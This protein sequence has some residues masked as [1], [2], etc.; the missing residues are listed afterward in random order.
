[1]RFFTLFLFAL[2]TIF[3]FSY[4]QTVSSDSSLF[5]AF[6]YRNVGPTRG[7]RVTTVAG[8][9][10]QAG[11]FYMGAT[12]G[13]VWKT[14]D[15]GITWKNI[16]DG[17][18]NTP[19]IGAIRVAPTNPD[20][21]YVGTGSD[22]IR[23]NVIIGKGVYKSINAGK[24]WKH[25]GLEKVGQIGAVE[26]HPTNPEIIFVAAQG[27]PFQ[28]NPERGVYQSKDG[29]ASWKQVLFVADSVGAVDVEFA[30]ANPN[31]VYATM[32]RNE[33][34]PWT[35][36]SGANKVGGVYKSTDGG[37]TWKK[38]TEGLPQGLI[39]KI[40]LAVSAADPNRLY[41]LVEAPKGEA[42]LYRSEDQ[43]NSFKLMSTKKEL[44]ARPFYYLNV[45]ANPLNADVV[46]VNEED[47]LKSTDG[48]KTWKEIRTP[49]GDNHDMWMNPRD[50]S[51]FI[52]SN[53]GGA[54]ITTNGGKT[55][56]PQD[57]QPTA[58]LYQVAVDDQYPYWLYAGQQ[59]NST[60]S[61]PSLPPYDPTRGSTSYWLAVGG[62]ETG[63]AV[64][65]PGNHN[66]V[67]S[68]CKGRFGVFDKRTG[69]ERQYYVGATNMYGHNPKD[70]VY[71]FQRV[72]PIHV[73]PH[74]PDVVYHTSQFVHMT[75]NDGISWETISPDLTANE[76]SKQVIS[77]SPI[78]RDITG[79]EYYS[80]I[81][82]I[83]ESTVKA[84]I[85]WTG[86]NDGPIYV[87][88]DAGKSW[89][90][91]TPKNV[92]SGGRVDCVEPSPH[93][94]GKAYAAILRYQLGDWK[95][96][97]VKTNDYG[98]TWTLITD[99]KNGIPE[100]Y[101]VRTIR[102]DPEKEGLLFAGTEFGLFVS[103]DDGA[104]WK[105]FQQNLPVTPVTDI[106]IF[107]NDLI[108]STMGRSFW[109]MDNISPLR[110]WNA[111][112]APN[113]FAVNDT[114]RYRYRGTGINDVPGYPAPGV[115][116]DYF[117][118]GQATNLKME[119]LNSNG[120]IIRTY[121]GKSSAKDSVK[122]TQP[123]MATGFTSS[124]SRTGLNT[125][126]GLHRFRWDMRHEGAWDANASRSLQGG[127]LIVPGK[128]TIQLMV[129]EKKFSQSFE[130][131]VDPRIKESG[132]GL[133]DLKAQEKLS[134]EIRN[135]QNSS[136]KTAE[137]IKTRRKELDKKIKEGKNVKNAKIENQELGIVLDKLVTADVIY[138]TP[139]L[140]DQLNYLSS[141]LNQ[142][143]QRPGKDAYDRLNE[144]TKKYSV[145]LEEYNKLKKRG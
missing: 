6:Q 21:V 76:P 128:Y 78:T 74:N 48:G 12:G 97:I 105:S 56:S 51:V 82:D 94:E 75:T 57:N 9:G 81:Y 77:G 38:M 29:G 15:Y 99:G 62:C 4:S 130:I 72:S 121:S 110:K 136:K 52:Q 118:S 83:N 134:L 58:E 122:A 141:M 96:Y 3:S 144:L 92:P 145:I 50:T 37:A 49:H 14:E 87:T 28:K 113:L 27:Q 55:W 109:I 89:S 66:I 127:A 41:A 111:G 8:V 119:I 70:L 108:L 7:G 17:F 24:T 79:E 53:D 138:P 35:I 60:I 64:P 16:S 22:G 112:S 90:N 93:K 84:G 125:E 95:P 116:V 129:D 36:I 86:A 140:I 33:R 69:Q 133:D 71:R 142:A 59:D 131:L 135:L 115:I 13:G 32:W 114:H 107:R 137:E 101:P 26:I 46:F 68:D 18:F 44:Y 85:I 1:M 65:K 43:G 39:G 98:S 91:V 20:I 80:T 61:V 139:M 19:S 40:D 120:N 25:I 100:D 124:T 5:K 143:D 42:G 106:K 104:T 132:V 11:T 30:P 63:P 117:L 88:K 123:D 45:D 73:S 102:E 31:I 47:F 23:S 126:A 67:Y 34:K 10:D 2:L 103:L 54:N